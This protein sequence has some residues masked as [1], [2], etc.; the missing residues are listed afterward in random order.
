MGRRTDFDDTRTLR[1]CGEGLYNGFT[2]AGVMADQRL[3]AR[4]GL[5]GWVGWTAPVGPTAA[6]AMEAD[7]KGLQGG[8]VLRRSHGTSSMP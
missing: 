3:I 5:T 6:N 1:R 7:R 2:A 4:S 8:T